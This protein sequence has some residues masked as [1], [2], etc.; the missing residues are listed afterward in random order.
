MRTID[1]L[2]RY[3]FT[4]KQIEALKEL[5]IINW[6]WGNKGFKFINLKKRIE[7]LPFLDKDRIDS[8]YTDIEQ[9]CNYNHDIEFYLWGWFIDY[10]KANYL[11]VLNIIWLLRWTSIRWRVVLFLLMLL[12]LLLFGW[13]YFNWWKRKDINN[14]YILL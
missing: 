13:K 7:K 12:G 11:F 5:N 10:I 2:L 3:K 4:D 9:L 8:L 14:L 6:C 1:S